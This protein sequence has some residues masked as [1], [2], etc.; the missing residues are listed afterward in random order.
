MVPAMARHPE[1]DGRSG[2]HRTLATDH[3]NVGSNSSRYTV[4]AAAVTKLLNQSQEK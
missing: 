1:A 4:K 2:D 3:R